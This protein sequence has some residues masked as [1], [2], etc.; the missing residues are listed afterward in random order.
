MKETL[1]LL[2]GTCRYDNLYAL[3]KLTIKEIHKYNDVIDIYWLICLDSYNGSCNIELFE[4]SL[5]DNNI[6]YKICYSGKPNQSNYG[7]DLFNILDDDNIIH[8]RLISSFIKCANNN[9][10]GDKEIIT[11]I[12]KWDCGHNREIDDYMI[13]Y[14][15]DKEPRLEWFLFDPSQVIIKYSIIQKYN[16]IGCGILYDFYWLNYPVIDE[17]FKNDNVIFYKD[18]D[19]G[20]GKHIVTSYHN[21]L[22]QLNKINNFNNKNT[23]D[24]CF[25]LLIQHNDIDTPLNIPIFKKETKE[26]ILQLII[27]DYKDLYENYK[28]D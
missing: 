18:Y 28:N 5:I 7:G 27:K 12:N 24:I 22:I 21:G 19:N 3:S 10:Y 16:G 11:F 20:Y 26:K 6:K 2:T 1:I 15:S 14:K 9:F 8:P 17:E 13:T 25:D 23:D 4:K